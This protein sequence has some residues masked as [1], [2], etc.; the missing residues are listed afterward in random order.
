M[1]V[2]EPAITAVDTILA[3][4]GAVGA[5]RTGLRYRQIAGRPARLPAAAYHNLLWR[6][7]DY[8]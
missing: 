6:R 3:F 5:A 4:L 7:E 8:F 1:R 2:D